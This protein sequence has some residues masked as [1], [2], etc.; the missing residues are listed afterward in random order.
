MPVHT[1]QQVGDPVP[2]RGSRV[3]STA[4]AELVREVLAGTVLIETR[5]FFLEGTQSLQLWGYGLGSKNV[6]LLT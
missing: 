4:R 2:Q 1:R 6:K 5:K 3:V